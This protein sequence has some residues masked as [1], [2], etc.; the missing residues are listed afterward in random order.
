MTQLNEAITSLVEAVAYTS[1]LVLVVMLLVVGA[2]ELR[3]RIRRSDLR[4]NAGDGATSR[5]RDNRRRSH[6]AA[7]AR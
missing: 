4:P 3:S 7:A 6:R 5:H 2:L 1:M